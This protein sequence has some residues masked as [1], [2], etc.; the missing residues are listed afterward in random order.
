MITVKF[1]C[2]GC[3]K[4]EEAQMKRQFVSL[5]GKGYGFGSYHTD[6]IDEITPEGWIAFDPW[7]QCTYCPE[8]WESITKVEA[9]Q[10]ASP[11]NEADQG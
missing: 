9:Q 11:S 4:T 7:T 5:N 3:F 1:E 2:G 10:S 6:S 8:C